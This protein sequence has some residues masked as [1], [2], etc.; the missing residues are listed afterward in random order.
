MNAR[1]KLPKQSNIGGRGRYRVPLP[2]F[3]WYRSQN[4][5]TQSRLK[6]I[7]WAFLIFVFLCAILYFLRKPILIAVGDALVYESDLQPADVI[8]VLGGGE[9]LRAEQASKLYHE[10]Y[11]QKLL[12]L[13]PKTLPDDAPYRDLIDM[14]QKLAVKVFNY[15]NVP[16][17]HIDWA[18][19]P[20]F[21]T[22]EETLLI[23]E[24]MQKNQATSAIVVSGYF[25]S[26]RAQWVL[27][28]AFEDTG[29]RIQVT[30]AP[31]PD[32]NVEN[33]WSDIEGILNVQNE[34]IKYAYYRLRGL[35]GRQ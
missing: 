22:Y 35:L 12:V 30:P 34:Y 24:W 7:L 32:L 14:E 5:S 28:R 23:K 16:Q 11:S 6:K 33:W 25:Q 1:L 20:V 29:F 2:P 27:D 18:A 10:G 21:S 17:N 8:V 15:W 26:S 9:T 13:L 3:A 31:E 19:R 4:T